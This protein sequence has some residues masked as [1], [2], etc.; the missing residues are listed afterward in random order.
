[1][2]KVLTT[3][4]LAAAATVLLPAGAS[5]AKVHK[6]IRY[7][8]LVVQQGYFVDNDPSGQSGGDLFGSTGVLRRHSRETGRFSSACTASSAEA[9]QCTATLIWNSGDR[10]QLAG[11]IHVQEDQNHL[12]I[13][14][15]AKRYK[16]ARGDATLTRVDD[17]G[18]VQRI[19]LRILR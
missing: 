4:A 19:R 16:Q 13:V 14:G 6:Q 1:V 5:A 15:G 8:K 11:E 17:Q 12:A 9:A 18:Q 2:K 7:V 3:L 10:I